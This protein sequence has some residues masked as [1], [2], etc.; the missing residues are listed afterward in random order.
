MTQITGKARV[1]KKTKHLAQRLRK[2]EIAVI[3]HLDLDSTCARMLVDCKAAA[4]INASKSISG[5][6]PNTG[7]SILLAAGI[8]ILDNVGK[9]IMDLV[10]EGDVISIEGE[11]VLKNGGVVAAGKM[12]STEEVARMMEEARSNL[13]TELEKFVQ[14]TLRFIEEEKFLILDPVEVPD[15]KTKIAGRHALIVVRGEG[16]KE[17]LAIIKSYLQDVKPV[18]IGVDGG[19]DALLDFGFKPDLIVGDMDSVS[20]EALKCGAEIVVHAYGNGK[21]PGLSR[22][23][24]LGLE[25]SVF[26]LQGTSEDMAMMLAYEKGADLIVAVGTHSN[27]IDFLDKGRAGMASTFLTRLKIGSKLVDAKGVSRLYR[28]EPKLQELFTLILAAMA[29]V[30]VVAFQ[31]PAVRTWMGLIFFKLR[32]LL[33]L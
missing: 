26:P 20:D 4:V 33:G 29:V 2:G 8:P 13:A 12:L 5:R 22:V 7:P 31:S 19:A 25:A 11:T 24:N 15:L 18:L 28:R 32:K 16:Y 17:D 27:L 9:K 14:N 1:D 23:K 30:F 10:S 21:A 6:Y 3:D